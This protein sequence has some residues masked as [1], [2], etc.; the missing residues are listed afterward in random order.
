MSSFPF[1][2]WIFFVIII[3]LLIQRL[4][5][6]YQ[7]RLQHTHRLL[8]LLL[9][10]LPQQQWGLIT[11]PLSGPAHTL[12]RPALHI[13]T[14]LHL[15]RLCLLQRRWLLS[16]SGPAAAAGPSSSAPATRL[17]SS[18]AMSMRPQGHLAGWRSSSSPGA[19]NNTSF[20]EWLQALLPRGWP[21]RQPL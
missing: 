17:S 13:L 15:L 18:A 4:I 14:P 7:W 12:V 19:A 20:A 10:Q 16:P 2:A 11:L 5:S 6:C 3:Y 1:L 8:T 9:S 21:Q